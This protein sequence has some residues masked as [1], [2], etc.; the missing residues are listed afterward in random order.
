MR[1]KER[2]KCG[3][4][5]RKLKHV[6]TMSCT[7][8]G[9]VRAGSLEV[10]SNCCAV[11]STGRPVEDGQSFVFVSSGGEERVRQDHEFEIK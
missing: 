5:S 2:Q 1:E 8:R 10:D 4:E 6:G 3:H 9:E 11:V 7:D